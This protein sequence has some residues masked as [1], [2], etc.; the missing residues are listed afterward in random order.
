MVYMLATGMTLDDLFPNR[1]PLYLMW[2]W[3]SFVEGWGLALSHPEISLPGLF[4]FGIALGLLFS[5]H[6]TIAVATPFA[7]FWTWVGTLPGI[8]HIRKWLGERAMRKEVYEA[9]C[10]EW[11]EEILEI[12]QSKVAAGLWT[13]TQAK[14]WYAK[15]SRHFPILKY[16][17]LHD[18]AKGDVKEMIRERMLNEHRDANGKIIPVPVP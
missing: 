8:R 15:F 14:E 2:L 7:A 17:A 13:E 18:D 6:S 12:G 9:Q 16:A 3:R 5:K 11:V 10:E 4:L 1:D